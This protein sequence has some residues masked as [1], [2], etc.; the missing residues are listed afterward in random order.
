[1]EITVPDG[2]RS[3]E[4]DAGEFTL[5]S[6]T[7]PTDHIFMARDIAAVATDG[8]M[9]VLSSIP[10]TADGLEAYWR[11]DPSLD[12]SPAQRTTIADGIEATTFLI[13]VSEDA[14]FLLTDCPGY[15]RCADFFTDPEHWGGGVY[16][17]AAPAAVRLFLVTIGSAND[18]HLL[19]IG[20]E[21]EDDQALERLTADAEPIIASI[22]LPEE[23]VDW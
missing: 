12:V 23:L 15:P 5:W 19:V 6:T 16:G 13:R 17:I 21:A 22:R 4:Q 3:L 10:R 2:W 11:G 20:L 8:S 14:D 7:H 18:E 9:Q 1:M